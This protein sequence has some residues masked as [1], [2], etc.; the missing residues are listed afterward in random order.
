MET[1][2]ILIIL[3]IICVVI[4]LLVLL[5]KEKEIQEKNYHFYEPD[6][7]LSA[8][9]QTCN[10]KIEI[11]I[12]KIKGMNFTN[13]TINEDFLNNYCNELKENTWSC[14]KYLVIYE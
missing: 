8:L 10:D 3:G 12:M 9:N 7:Q 13:E 1:K 14:N 4:I 6:C 11:E 2:K 5:P